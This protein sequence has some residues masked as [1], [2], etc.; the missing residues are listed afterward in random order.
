MRLMAGV[1][2]VVLTGLAGTVAAQQ[3]AQASKEP[4]I[5]QPL[6]AAE[7]LAAAKLTRLHDTRLWWNEGNRVIGASFKGDDASD[8]TLA[9]A[10]ALP[11]LRSVVLVAL[12]ECQLTDNGLEELTRLPRLELLT[13]VGNRI[14]DSGMVHVARLSTLRV[15]T[16]NCNVTDTGLELLAYL[17]NLERLD[18]TQTRITDAGLGHLKNYARL[19]TLV[20]NGTQL[21]DEALPAIAQ[22][23]TLQQ[24]YLGHTSVDDAAVASLMHM[25]Q[26]QLL[27]VVDTQMTAKGVEELQPYF[28]ESCTIIHQSGTY[29]GT[30]KSPVAMAN[31]PARSASSLTPTTWHPAK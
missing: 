1:W 11:G 5:V 20:L 3:P 15:L 7:R 8:R 2:C 28:L 23:K 25:E 30:R 12:P 9:L 10:S 26:L 13:I 16:L 27:Y 29:Q 31:V 14:T 18:L 17:P 22:L 21:T 19:T 4:P 6:T 24:L